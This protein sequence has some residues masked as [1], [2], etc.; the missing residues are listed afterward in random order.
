VPVLV[1]TAKDLT[2]EDRE[3]LESGAQ[4]VLQ[5]TD[6]DPAKL[7]AQVRALTGKGPRS[8]DG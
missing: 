8:A 3:R 2:A 7:L 5:K 1:V 4:R 6:F